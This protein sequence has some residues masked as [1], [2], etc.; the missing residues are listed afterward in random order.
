MGN[1][2]AKAM[3]RLHKL[4]GETI[5]ESEE[6]AVI[7]GMPKDAISRGAVKTVTPLYEIAER[8]A[9]AVS[10]ISITKNLKDRG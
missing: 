5:A 7:Y 3:E 4:G 10:K 6:T 9:E 2:G 1:D 8:I